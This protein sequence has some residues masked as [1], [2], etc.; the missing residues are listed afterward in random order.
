[1]TTRLLYFAV[2][3]EDSA[4]AAAQYCIL[5]LKSDSDAGPRERGNV[6]PPS[7]CATPVAEKCSRAYSAG[8]PAVLLY[9]HLSRFPLRL[10]CIDSDWLS[11]PLLSLRAPPRFEFALS[12]LFLVPCLSFYSKYLYRICSYS[13]SG[14]CHWSVLAQLAWNFQ[15]GAQNFSC[16]Y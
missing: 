10:K 14:S 1:M 12:L 7:L 2:P 15:L 5:K 9:S 16:V 3:I 8:L 4:F 6:P 13:R 11:S